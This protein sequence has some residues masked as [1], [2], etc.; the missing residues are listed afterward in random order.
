MRNTQAKT[1][2]SLRAVQNF[3]AA[4]APALPAVSSSGL[5]IRLDEI[6]AVAD[7][8][9]TT[10]SGS[11]L[12]AQRATRGFHALRLAVL[13]DHMAPIAKIAALDLPVSPELAPLRVPRRV[14]S[15]ERLRALAAGM[16][17][18]AAPLAGTFV[19]AG[20]PPDFAERLDRAAHA[21]LDAVNERKRHR[22]LRRGATAGIRTALSRGRK[23]VHALDAMMTSALQ[24]APASLAAWDLAKRVEL[25]S[26]CR[27]PGSPALVLPMPSAPSA[28]AICAPLARAA[29]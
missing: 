13:R 22:V 21:M 2:Q 23:I 6:V 19:A 9:A 25:V 5:C 16:A 15:A 29:A 26:T 8:H 24:D 10:Q 12:A 11:A 27:R 18:A 1:L 20:L 28:A 17:E 3:L 4:H 7:G 14:P